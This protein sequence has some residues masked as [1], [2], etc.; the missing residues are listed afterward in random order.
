MEAENV[1]GPIAT[2]ARA[3]MGCGAEAMTDD[4]VIEFTS[5]RLPLPLIGGQEKLFRQ[6]L[7]EAICD[8]ELE[9]LKKRSR[10]GETV[11]MEQGT[12]EEPKNFIGHDAMEKIERNKSDKVYCAA[13]LRKQ[14]P[15]CSV[16]R[17]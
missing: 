13:G 6:E 17:A 15:S 14:K 8:A 2:L 7:Q 12:Y 3:A 4:F 11:L 1:P 9:K 10:E 16:P 5:G